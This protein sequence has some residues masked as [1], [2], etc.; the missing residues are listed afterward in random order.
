MG[1]LDEAI[2][3][4]LELKRQHGAEETELEGLE[5]EAF[6]PADR[7]DAT[8]ANTE[9][10]SPGSSVTVPAGEGDQLDKVFEATRQQAANQATG[11]AAT[12]EEATATEH[13]IP[14][15]EATSE[16]AAQP[17]ERFQAEDDGEPNWSD[18][19]TPQGKTEQPTVESPVEPEPEP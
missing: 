15:A 16:T 7:P 11:E 9:V 1:I 17:E 4:H 13:A 6:G 10:I 14:G 2:R 18:D 19:K 3:E 8:E 5:S 12:G